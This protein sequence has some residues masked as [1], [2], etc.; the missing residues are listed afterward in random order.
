MFSQDSTTIASPYLL[1][2]PISVT[3]KNPWFKCCT[4]R[5]FGLLMSYLSPLFLLISWTDTSDEDYLQEFEAFSKVSARRT[6]AQIA[7]GGFIAHQWMQ[8][9]KVMWRLSW[10]P[11]WLLRVTSAQLLHSW[12]SCIGLAPFYGCNSHMT[13][14][15]RWR[16]KSRRLELEPG[17]S[18]VQQPFPDDCTLQSH[19]WPHSVVQ[20][21]FHRGPWKQ[22]FV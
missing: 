17:D 6:R 2:A 13:L 11:H 20:A 8:M 14:K 7:L 18:R 12:C 10:P 22:I 16:C 4:L 15:E 21:E 3:L 19:I 1:H 5:L 9:E